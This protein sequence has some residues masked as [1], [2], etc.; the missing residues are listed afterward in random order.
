MSWGDR[1]VKPHRQGGGM[2]GK[3]MR[4]GPR[5]CGDKM[6]EAL[7]RLPGVMWR[8]RRE[9]AEVWRTGATS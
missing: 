3:P 1:N 2:S 4:P 6:V 9:L 7:V 8:H 5:K